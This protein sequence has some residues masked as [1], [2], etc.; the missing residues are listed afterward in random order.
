VIECVPGGLRW[1]R[2]IRIRQRLGLLPR[3]RLDDR[4][5]SYGLI[6]DS[7]VWH[8]RPRL[9]GK[10]F[11]ASLLAVDRPAR[12]GEHPVDF[13]RHDETFSGSPLIFLVLSETVA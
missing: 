12:A 13:A 9:I 5:L 10:G 2:T 6:V 3:L 11:V 1:P 4:D 8:G 7:D